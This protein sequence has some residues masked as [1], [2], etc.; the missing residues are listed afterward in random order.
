[1]FNSYT[2]QPTCVL[3]MLQEC[4]VYNEDYSMSVETCS[5]LTLIRTY[6]TIIKECSYL[7]LLNS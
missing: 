3:F 5:C 6:L 4:S 7:N 2:F 1:M